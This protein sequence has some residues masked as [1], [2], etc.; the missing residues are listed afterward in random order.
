M[1]LKYLDNSITPE[2]CDDLVEALDA[3]REIPIMGSMI[4]ATLTNSGLLD[5]QEGNP[6][7]QRFGQQDIYHELKKLDEKITPLKS[8]LFALRREMMDPIPDPI[9][10]KNIETYLQD[11]FDPQI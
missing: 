6:L 8:K 11:D 10:D 2:D 7:I 9:E 1:L 3:I 4:V 5:N